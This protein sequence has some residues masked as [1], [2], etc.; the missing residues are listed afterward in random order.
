[1]AT[2]SFGTGD[3][4]RYPALRHEVPLEI[5]DPLLFVARRPASV[6]TNA[7]ERARIAE[8]LPDARAAARRRARASTSCSR[9]ACRATRPSSRS[10]SGRVQRWGIEAAVVPGDLPVALADRLRA[11]GSSST[12]TRRVRGAPP[13]QDAGRA[14]R[15]SAAPSA[16]P[17]PGMA[18]AAALIRGA[19]RAATGCCSTT[20]SRS[21]PRPCARRSA[22][23]APRPARPR[24][25]TSWSCRA[26]SGGGHDPGSGPLPADLPIK[27]DL[28]PRDEAS[29]CWADMT[30]T[31]VVGEVTDEVAD[32]ARRRP[33]GARGRTRR[34]PAR[35]SPAARSTTP[36]PTSSSAPAIPTQRTR[37]PGETLTH[38]LLL[39]ARP[40]RRPRGPRAARPR[41]GRP[42]RRSSPATSSRS[43]PA[44]RA[45]R[46]SAACASRTSC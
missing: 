29:G 19:E 20:A 13:R 25:R 35:A 6:L 39:R 3:T 16:P 15:A 14:R 45:S 7:L 17:R 22:P 8:A 30:R 10:R 33:R 4:V 5:V 9:R 36:P 23:P 18:A 38:G 1:M 12:S 34:R 2:S 44:S 27:I 37:E 24:R 41:P 32:A 26:L 11:G 28:W 31:F 21:P 46:A 43:S 40:R 42:R